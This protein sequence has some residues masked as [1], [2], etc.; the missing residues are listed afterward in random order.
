MKDLGRTATSPADVAVYSQVLAASDLEL[1]D[2]AMDHAAAAA[3]GTSALTGQTY[4]VNGYTTTN[5]DPAAYPRWVGSGT[6]A[7]L[8][9]QYSGATLL[10]SFLNAQ[11][12]QA[13]ITER[14]RWTINPNTYN[15]SVTAGD[16]NTG[17]IGIIISAANFAGNPSAPPNA[18]CHLAITPL[19]WIYSVV[20]SGSV[21]QLATD[22]FVTPL[23]QDGTTIHTAEVVIDRVA[24]AAYL[25]LPDNS[26]RKVSPINNGFFTWDTDG[27][28][29]NWE[30]Y[31]FSGTQ[32]MIEIVDLGAD[33]HRTD[34]VLKARRDYA[35][36]PLAPIPPWK[37][38]GTLVVKTGTDRWYNDTGRMI[39][40]R[41]V[42]AT[43]GTAPTGSSIIVDVKKNGTTMYTTTG[44][45]PTIAVSTTTTAATLPDV[46]FLSPGDYMTVDI[47][48][49]GSTVAG[50]DLTVQFLFALL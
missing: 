5:S 36:V 19:A 23:A 25:Y 33:A 49:V 6:A 34:R 35:N 9:S 8:T 22:N 44:N 14:A 39:Q 15:G 24:D 11:F 29:A 26:I 32:K 37:Q 47:A 30:I 12:S 10:G 20:L 48:Q 2:R 42:R 13:V 17:T 40:V 27:A 31:K 21:I 3:S 1:W 50:A 45:R 43:V 46:T 28:Y 38:N 18:I 7:R 41:A 16:A 4:T